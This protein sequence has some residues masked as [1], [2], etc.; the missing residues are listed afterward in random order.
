M[1]TGEEDAVHFNINNVGRKVLN[2]EA[3]LID[4]ILTPKFSHQPPDGKS[5]GAS[6]TSN[7]AGSRPPPPPPP[8]QCNGNGQYRCVHSARQYI[9]T[10]SKP[11]KL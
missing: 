7:E 10:T 3:E 4:Q 5:S 1:K 6:N 8:T 9:I 2:A 11:I